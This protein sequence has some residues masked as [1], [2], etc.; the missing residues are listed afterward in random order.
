MHKVTKA[1]NLSKCIRNAH[2]SLWLK[3]ICW[4]GLRDH[5]VI[6]STLQFLKYSTIDIKSALWV[7]TSHLL[8]RFWSTFFLTVGYQKKRTHRFMF[9]HCV[10]CMSL[11]R[12]SHGLEIRKKTVETIIKGNSTSAVTW[13]WRCR[14]R[15]TVH[16]SSPS[17]FLDYYFQIFNWVDT[18]I[19]LL[20]I[21]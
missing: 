18:I 19:P 15:S 9:E 12:G 17:C 2:R 4:S 14:N 7:W 3:R 11:E 13:N 16:R 8:L 5:L 21:T 10:T 6:K 1:H 20:K